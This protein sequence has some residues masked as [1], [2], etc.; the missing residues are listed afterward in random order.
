MIPGTFE[1]IP[2]DFDDDA[3]ITIEGNLH[4]KVKIVLISRFIR[5]PFYFFR[6][7]RIILYVLQVSIILATQNDSASSQSAIQMMNSS[8]H[9]INESNNEDS[10]QLTEPATTAKVLTFM[11]KNCKQ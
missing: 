11:T 2:N 1:R 3:S 7:I 5:F 10:S 9:G 8:E 6:F 4:Y